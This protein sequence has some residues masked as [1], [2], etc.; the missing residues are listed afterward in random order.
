M[1]TR[2]T[3]A[4]DAEFVFTPDSTEEERAEAVAGVLRLVADAEFPALFALA[5]YDDVREVEIEE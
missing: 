3:Q 5:V 1:T 2:I 4:R